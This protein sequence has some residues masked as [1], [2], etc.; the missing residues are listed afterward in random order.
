VGLRLNHVGLFVADFD[1]SMRYY[2]ETLGLREA[3]TIRDQAGNPTLAYLHI[4]RDTFLEIAPA[5]E[6][7][8]VGISHVGL[9]PEDLEQTLSILRGR[10]VEIA[11]P[12]T[13]STGSRLANVTDPNGVRLELVDFPP[14]STTRKAIDA[15]PQ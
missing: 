12:R 11:D 15:F 9:W 2:T 1:E 6:Q 4:T 5:S 7:R 3:F 10:G 14:D 8:P 13:G